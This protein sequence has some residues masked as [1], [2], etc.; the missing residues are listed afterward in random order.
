MLDIWIEEFVEGDL[1][2]TDKGW[3]VLDALWGVVDPP[4]ADALFTEEVLD[5]LATLKHLDL[6]L[7]AKEE[8]HAES[9]VDGHTL[10]EFFSC[11]PIDNKVSDME[12][13]GEGLEL[14]HKFVEE[15]MMGVG[16]AVNS[17]RYIAA[18]LRRVLD[19]ASKTLGD[20]VVVCT[21]QTRL[22]FDVLD[23]FGDVVETQVHGGGRVA[24][25]MMSLIYIS[26]F[27]CQ[28]VYGKKKTIGFS[29]WYG[30]AQ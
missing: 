25:D 9:S 14:R 4:L 23:G 19:K 1:V 28:T 29:D 24:M 18:A 27:T 5:A 12:F 30:L 15:R 10:E 22:C 21:G 7:A 13:V 3:Y 16:C 8:M 20:V 17:V 6:F 2:C 26:D 11:F